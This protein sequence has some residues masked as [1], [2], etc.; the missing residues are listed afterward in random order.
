MLKRCMEGLGVEVR[1]SNIRFHGE[2]FDNGPM[3]GL[4]RRMY[5]DRLTD[6]SEAYLR[7]AIAEHC[8]IVDKDGEHPLRW[9]NEQWRVCMD[10][11][12]YESGF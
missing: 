3:D 12:R 9:S 2:N 8:I 4:T 1:D 10:S 11:I 5:W 7:E 6:L